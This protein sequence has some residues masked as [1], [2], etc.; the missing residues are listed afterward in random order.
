MLCM[1]QDASDKELE[2]NGSIPLH[3]DSPSDV[4]D[5]HWSEGAVRDDGPAEA[6]V[7]EDEPDDENTAAVAGDEGLG[8]AEAEEEGDEGLDEAEAEEEV[9][10]NRHADAGDETSKDWCGC[11]CLGVGG[12]V[13]GCACV[14]AY[15]CARVRA[16]DKGVETALP[17]K[18]AMPKSHVW[19]HGMRRQ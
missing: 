6:A 16:C 14:R 17:K 7:A 12:W 4:E 9:P 11:G 3:E 2:Q 8:E 18:L 10:W 19:H 13:G 5:P 1:S 15:V